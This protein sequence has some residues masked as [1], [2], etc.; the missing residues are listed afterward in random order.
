MDITQIESKITSRTRAIMVVH[1]YGHPAEMDS[2]S[3]TA[4]EYNLVVIEDAAEAHGALY[5]NKRCGSMGD[6]NCFS[7]HA[8][9]N[10]TTGEGGA[11]T[12]N[13]TKTARFIDKVY[14][15]GIDTGSWSRFIGRVGP[16]MFIFPNQKKR[17]RSAEVLILKLHP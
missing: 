8:A 13:N 1:I 7:F 11:I 6:I 3:K 15:H 12:T 4:K 16:R 9:K 14:F 10:M 2:I 17:K 5:K